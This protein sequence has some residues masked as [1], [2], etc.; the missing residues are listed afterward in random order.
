MTSIMLNTSWL[1]PGYVSGYIH[2]QV[3]DTKKS[4]N[5]VLSPENSPRLHTAALKMG[6]KLLADIQQE[7]RGALP[8]PIRW[9]FRHLVLPGIAKILVNEREK[10]PFLYQ[11][12]EEQGIINAH[13]L[14][15]HTARMQHLAPD[16]AWK[17]GEKITLC[18]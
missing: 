5:I 11:K 1:I 13:L 3:M 7:K 8:L 14:R 18:R 12:M 9:L 15:R 2:K 4:R 17:T 6:S 10:V 16:R